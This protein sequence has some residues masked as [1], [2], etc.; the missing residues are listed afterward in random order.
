MSLRRY[1]ACALLVL[2]FS[3]FAGSLSAAKIVPHRALYSLSFGDAT[4]HGNVIDARGVMFFE[5]LETC[6]G[7]TM[8]QKIRMKLFDTQGREI[9]QISDYSSWESLDGKKFRFKVRNTSDGQV[10]TELL[11]RASLGGKGGK[12]R[13]NYS[14]PERKRIDL[15][16]GA[17]FPTAHTRMLIEQALA[18]ESQFS[19]VVFDGNDER[20]AFEINAVIGTAFSPRIE[21]PRTGKANP[22]LINHTAW[23]MRLAFYLETSRTPAPEFEVGLE[24]LDNG[25]APK[26]VYDYGDYT[27]KAMLDQ[28]EAAAAPAC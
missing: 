23:R 4:S 24:I 6:D 8:E 1:V 11:G 13:A 28:V 15:P 10:L 22:L 2:A 18:G 21:E 14:K 19:R 5:W 7:W 12:G 25:I 3:G 16:S 27:I 26:L 20:G 9:E 17:L